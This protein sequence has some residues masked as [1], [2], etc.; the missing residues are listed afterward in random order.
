MT[1]SRAAAES[2]AV[3]AEVVVVEEVV[4]SC[5]VAESRAAAVEVKAA[6]LLALSAI[7]VDEWLEDLRTSYATCPYFEDVLVALGG[8][9]PSDDT[10]EKSRLRHKR[11]K[12]YS[13][14][15]DG[16]IRQRLQGSL[17]SRGRNARRPCG[18]RMIRQWVA[19]SGN[20]SQPY[21]KRGRG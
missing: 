10:A 17:L 19:T 2:R 13:L 16:L 9:A 4:E 14:E 8:R 7:H 12:Q 6:E 21:G 3:E 15:K 18:K 20:T 1:E 5:V 11:P